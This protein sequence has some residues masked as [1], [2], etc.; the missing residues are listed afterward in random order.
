VSDYLPAFNG[1]GKHAVTVHHLTAAID[2]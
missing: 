2:D 1:D